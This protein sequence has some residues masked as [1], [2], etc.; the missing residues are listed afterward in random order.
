MNM[1]FNNSPFLFQDGCDFYFLLNVFCGFDHLFCNYIKS[2]KF[3]IHSTSI[4]YKPSDIRVLHFDH[5][6]YDGV[7]GV[8]NFL[9]SLLQRD[10]FSQNVM[11]NKIIII[12]YCQ[13]F[14]IITDR[15]SNILNTKR[16]NG[17]KIIFIQNIDN[18][19]SSKDLMLLHDKITELNCNKIIYDATNFDDYI[20]NALWY[21]SEKYNKK[22]SDIQKI[23]DFLILK[24]D[25]NN[26]IILHNEIE[27]VFIYYIDDIENENLSYN[28][29]FLIIDINENMI[30]NQLCNLF[31][32]GDF[33]G[34]YK[35]IFYFDLEN[36][37]L[38]IKTM[39]NRVDVMIGLKIYGKSIF[40]Y[41]KKVYTI[42]YVKEYLDKFTVE[43]LRSI[44][45]NLK[46]LEIDVKS[47]DIENF[48]SLSSFYLDYFYEK[49]KKNP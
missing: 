8:E 46:K 18:I 44:L 25:S 20:N 40:K 34:L 11:Q 37:L 16:M 7:D 19:N 48:N 1:I 23:K 10:L 26:Q 12:N 31:F 4:K 49:I 29:Y 22:L 24:F 9:L 43:N 33:I 36:I 14:S 42:T 27:N 39:V 5:I 21:F 32:L 3:P 38:F 13:I 15:I 45:S 28:N 6:F 41:S 2:L 17:I 35:K 30:V 47:G